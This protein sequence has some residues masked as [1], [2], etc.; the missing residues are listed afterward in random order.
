VAGA[1]AGT[2]LAVL[3]HVTIALG[4]VSLAYLLAERLSARAPL[5][6]RAIALTTAFASLAGF[7][8][9]TLGSTGA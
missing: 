5:V 4:A 9:F 2:V 7:A 3:L 1:I 6:A 8:W